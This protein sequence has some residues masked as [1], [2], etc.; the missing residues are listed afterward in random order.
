MEKEKKPKAPK[1]AKNPQEQ[2]EKKKSP[3]K[4]ILIIVAVLLVLAVAAGAAVY[5]FF[6]RGEESVE[7]NPKELSKTP[8]VYAVG[9]DEVVSLDSVMD[10]GAAMLTTVEAPTKTAEEEGIDEKTFRYKKAEDPQRLVEDYVKILRGEEQGFT[11]T[12]IDNQQLAEEPDLD[13]VSGSVILAKA[14][15]GSDTE[16]EDAA[17]MTFRVVVAWS[18]YAIAIQ[19]SHVAGAIQPPPEPEEEDTSA[20]NASSVSEQEEFFKNLSPSVLGL[21]G[22]SMSEYRLYPVD[23]WVQVNGYMCRQF[24]VYLLDM[25]AE[26]NSFLGTYYISDDLQHLFA[27]DSDR[28]IHVVDMGE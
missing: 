25:P 10:E 17:P 7:P 24:N 21:P 14:S 12:D 26:T 28:N 6:L 8:A 1:A 18:E 23:G 27:V 2:G 16:G 20:P 19:V 15:A 9:A 3:L 4:L 11:F 22:A 5:F 13:R